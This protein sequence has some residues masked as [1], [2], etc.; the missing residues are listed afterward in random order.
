MVA[1][2]LVPLHISSVGIFCQKPFILK[3]EVPERERE[4]SIFRKKVFN[5]QKNCS[6][7]KEKVFDPTDPSMRCFRSIELFFTGKHLGGTIIAEFVAKLQSYLSVLG[8]R[9][10]IQIRMFLGLLDQDPDPLVRGMDPDLAP[11]PDP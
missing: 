1:P 9:S 11:D 10:R 8:I 3:F 6:Q 7:N 4:L 5:I 2:P